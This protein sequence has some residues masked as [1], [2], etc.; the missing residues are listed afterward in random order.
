LS[1]FVVHISIVVILFSSV[2]SVSKPKYNI[3]LTYINAEST[4][5]FSIPNGFPNEF[6][7]INTMDTIPKDD[8]YELLD[9]GY[10][11]INNKEY[12][13]AISD[14]N[15]YL[16]TN[17][18]DTKIHMQLGYLYDATKQYSEAFKSFGFVVDNSTDLDEISKARTSMLYL[19]ELIYKDAPK[20]NEVKVLDTIPQDN[21]G[22]LLN[23][24]F[25]YINSKQYNEQSQS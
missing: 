21:S 3:P 22:D 17:P 14:F 2:V 1:K 16:I 15:A 24:G 23:K 6:I 8:S 13:E 19:K 25:N 5:S 7:F 20:I 18:K 9:K 12:T 4:S 10:I 11:H